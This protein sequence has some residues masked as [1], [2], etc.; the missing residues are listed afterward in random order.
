MAG[1]EP[2]SG[3]ERR[4]GRRH[5][6]RVADA[7]AGLR[8]GAQARDGA[9]ELKVGRCPVARAIEIDD[10]QARGAGIDPA[11][12]SRDGIIVE[13]SFGIVVALAKPDATAAPD[14]D[15]G[16]D[17]H[18]SFLIRSARSRHPRC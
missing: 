15:G 4:P 10:V 18:F 9:D 7:A 5:A 16:N 11:L 1:T 12:R 3:E 13:D 17:F 14:I 8:R 2:L 6:L